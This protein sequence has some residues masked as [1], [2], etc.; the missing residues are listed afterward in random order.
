[1]ELSEEKQTEGYR[2]IE[3]EK[4][5]GINGILFWVIIVLYLIMCLAAKLLQTAE[6]GS[7]SSSFMDC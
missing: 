4:Y 3:M 1:M 7:D 6:S 2:G 5:L